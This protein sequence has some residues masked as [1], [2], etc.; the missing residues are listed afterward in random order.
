MV[1]VKGKG[2][3]RIMIM[4]RRMWM[5]MGNIWL[6]LIKM[7]IKRETA[8]SIPFYIYSTIVNYQRKS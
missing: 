6:S 8:T 7:E 4:I 1:K 3:I 2:K 5:G